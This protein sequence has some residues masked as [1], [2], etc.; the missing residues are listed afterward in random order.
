MRKILRAKLLAGALAWSA[1][2]LIGVAPFTSA[3]ADVE[4]SFNYFHGQLANYGDWVY[5]DRWGEVWQPA[6]VAPDWRPYV[7]GHWVYTEDYGWLW[8]SDEP[9]GDITYHYGR[10]VN[11]ADDGWLWIPGYVW[12]PAWV[13]MRHSGE[14]TGWM[15]MPPD[16]R[17][18]AGDEIR[19]GGA[20][21]GISV[22]GINV[23]FNNWN[24]TN[25]RYGYA[26]WYGRDY[27]QDRF[28]AMWTFVPLRHFADSN[29]RSY[30]VPQ[31][32]VTTIIRTSTNITNYTVVNNYIVNKSV[33]VQAMQRAGAP[34][35]RP[36]RSAEII[37][38]P[39]L[40]VPIDRGQKIQTRMRM[41]MPRGTGIA[42][43]APKP[44]V[45]QVKTLS[46]RTPPVRP[47]AVGTAR[48]SHLLTRDSAAV[49]AR[50]NGS[51]PVPLTAQ[52]TAKAKV[53][54]GK[55]GVIPAPGRATAPAAPTPAQIR[56]QRLRMQGGARGGAKAATPAAPTPAEIRAQRLRTKGSARGGAEITAPAAPTPAEI[57][58]QRLRTQG[59]VR[60]G[61]EITTP[62]A[63][64]RAE[65]RA[66]RLRTQG[67]VGGGAEITTPAAPTRAEMRAQRL[68]TQGGVRGG[69]E[70]TTPAAPT[71]AE[72]RALRMRTQGGAKGGIETT[73]PH[74][75]TP[76]KI[77]T[78]RLRAPVERTPAEG[79][80]MRNQPLR[81]RA[82]PIRP[83]VTMPHAVVRPNRA[84]APA[85]Q[86]AGKAR[87]RPPPGG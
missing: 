77:R 87:K 27:S 85:E 24:D 47:G 65:M 25:D 22:G 55:S 35:V 20:F 71:R 78:P 75:P 3:V 63:P 67:G 14:Y 21:V 59:G 46:T 74:V 80:V 6:D 57:R 42:N 1:V 60:G 8:A 28:N 26:R 37:R 36:V 23:G 82:L 76:A 9:F 62:A 13:V 38:Q 12:S 33:N 4:V 30:E 56:D 48:S 68:H 15:P 41:E 39:G 58:A 45:A 16:E 70:A 64:T 51:K 52:E 17:F 83:A 29:Y 2:S 7:D 54:V 19:G 66:Q 72:I 18:L 43:S 69:A 44:T 5:S 34:P 81:E 10:W 86:P 73:T 61:A 31:Q 40:I 49:V 84:V 32:N 53:M 79:A 50:P 11:D